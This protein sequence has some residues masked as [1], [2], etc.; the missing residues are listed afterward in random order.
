MDGI[1]IID[2]PAGMTSHDVVFKV[3]KAIGERQIGH[4]GTLDPLATGVLVL[5]VGKATKL[6]KYFTEHDKTYRADL[7]VGYETDTLDREGTVTKTVRCDSLA[8][9]DVDAVL[10]AF[11]GWTQQ[12][13]PAFSAI[14]VG[15]KKLY[16]YARN[17]QELP[18]IDPRPVAIHDLIR[19]SPVRQ[20]DGVA[21]FSLFVHCGKGLYVRS[22]CRD[23]GQKLGYPATMTAL[24]RESV[25]AFTLAQAQ[26]L[27]EIQAGKAILR[28]PLGYLNLPVLVVDDDLKKKVLNGVFLPVSLFRDPVETLLLDHADQPLAIYTYDERLATMRLSVLW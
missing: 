8:E 1:L 18:D 20:S 17:H 9:S 16:E 21:G 15:G 6:V 2:K 11:L 26:S 25:G 5:C 3:R 19:T 4:T 14:R 22:L 27:P 12:M 28:D 24:R 10:P 23:I 7:E 13:P